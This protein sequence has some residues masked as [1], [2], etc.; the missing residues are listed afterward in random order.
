[1]NGM[2][3]IM[4]RQTKTVNESEETFGRVKEGID[5]SI[6]SIQAIAQQTSRLDAARA[7]V[8]GGVQNLSAVA[9][10]NAASTEET[11]ASAAEVS[12]I[13]GDISKSAEQLE[14]IADELK[15]NIGLFRL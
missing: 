14:D 13:M 6:A 10:E 2:Q 5:Q 15:K 1:M 9:Q 4:E 7:K 11:S 3:E 8:I 12:A